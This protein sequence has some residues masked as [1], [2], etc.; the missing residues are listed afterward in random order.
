MHSQPAVPAPGQRQYFLDWIRIFAFFVLIFYHTGMYYVTWGW[1]VKSPHA[2]DTL[3]PFMMLSGP[4]RLAL[5]F[6]ISGVASAFMLKKIRVGAFVRQRSVRLLL[7]LLF[8]MLVIVPPQSYFEVIEKLSYRG[9]YA[10]FMRLYINGYHGFCKDGECLRLPTWN[11]LW[12]VAYLWTYTLLLAA[13]A[14]LTPAARQERAGAALA[15]LLSG[16]RIIALPAA[17]LA[18]ARFAL[19][20]GYP[21]THALLDDWYNHA[22][23]FPLFLL[24]AT[25]ATQRSFWAGLEQARWPAL[26]LA[27][28]G[29]AALMIYYSIPEALAATPEVQAWRPVLRGV[30]A[31]VQWSAIAAV[32]GFGHRHLQF[33]SPARRYLTQAVFPVYIVHQTLIVSMAHGLKPVRLPPMLEGLILVLLT[34]TIS[35]A[36]VEVVRRVALLRPLFGLPLR[37]DHGRTPAGANADA[38]VNANTNGSENGNENGNGN[39]NGSMASQAN[40]ARAA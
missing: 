17:V 21:A 2:S 35:F 18:A 6:L 4:W 9:S 37:A 11:H 1:H 29:W 20:D 40:G 5:L 23:Y 8:G 36:V 19:V 15:R 30:Y 7:P 10:D 38:P 31:L 13:L 22:V 33:D 34:L 14:K 27:L 24:G 39:G 12:F 16:W 26:G 25:L 28:S 3:E 32:C